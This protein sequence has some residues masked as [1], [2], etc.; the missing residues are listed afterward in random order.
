MSGVA[1][2]PLGQGGYQPTLGLGPAR[3]VMGQQMRV[4]PGYPEAFQQVAVIGV[5]G[6]HHLDQRGPKGGR[7]SSPAGRFRSRSTMSDSTAGSQPLTA[8]SLEG[9]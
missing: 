5:E 6:R 4:R 3:Y 1:V 9:K 8:S 2:P 7:A